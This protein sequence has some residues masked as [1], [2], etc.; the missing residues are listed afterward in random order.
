MTAEAVVP[1]PELPFVAAFKEL[2]E[3]VQADPFQVSVAVDAPGDSSPP[4]AS[5][6]V[7]VPVAPKVFLAVF[8]SPTSVHDEPSYDSVFP[9]LGASPPIAKAAVCVPAPPAVLLPVFKFQPLA[10]AAAVY[11]NAEL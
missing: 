3:V 9:V 10:H 5:A 4:N 1:K 2:G 6:A 11:V 7:E 8:K